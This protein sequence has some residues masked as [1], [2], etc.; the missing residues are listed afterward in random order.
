MASVERLALRIPAG[1][2][3]ETAALHVAQLDAL[4][5]YLF[6]DL[7][8]IGAAELARQQAPG[9]NTIGMLLAHMAI[10]EV[11]WVQAG[12]LR[13]DPIDVAPVLGLGMDDDGM[14]LPAG[15]APPETLA[16]RDLAWYRDLFGRARTY[17]SAH[18]RGVHD[19][20]LATV[21]ERTRRDGTRQEFDGRWVLFHMVEHF[22]GHY[23]QVL[24]LRHLFRDGGP[25]R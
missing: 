11:F 16:G 24:L 3:S 15:G 25:P 19:A 17:A 14:P 21:V 5:S 2:A 9:F 8:G 13:R 22:A 23:G 7:E 1:F 18:L 4:T 12:I 6:D 20:Q 10:V